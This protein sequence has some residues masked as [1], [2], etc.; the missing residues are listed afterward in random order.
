MRSNAMVSL[1]TPTAT[2]MHKKPP[3]H[4]FTSC[5]TSPNNDL[6]QV[7]RGNGCVSINQKERYFRSQHMVPVPDRPR[8]LLRIY[9]IPPMSKRWHVVQSIFSQCP[10][11][12]IALVQNTRP[13]CQIGIQL[14]TRIMPEPM[15]GT[16]LGSSN[17]KQ[18][19]N[20]Y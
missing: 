8:F 7:G 5:F 9:G 11:M 18:K 3:T 15:S 19:V 16:T 12:E 17:G 6:S 2:T 10:T 4:S 14:H 20:L 1:W 13:S